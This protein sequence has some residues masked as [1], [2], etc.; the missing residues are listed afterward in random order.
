L[1]REEL[2]LKRELTE[3]MSLA[4]ASDENTKFASIFK[5]EDKDVA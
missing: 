3:K 5:K 1:L 2:Q 4:N